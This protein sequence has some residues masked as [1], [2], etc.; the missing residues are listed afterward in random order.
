MSASPSREPRAANATHTSGGRRL[1]CA[2]AATPIEYALAFI[3]VDDDGRSR[4]VSPIGGRCSRAG[5][6]PR[7]TVGDAVAADARSEAPPPLRSARLATDSRRVSTQVTFLGD[8]AV[9]EHGMT[10][11]VAHDQSTH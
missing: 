1:L 2:I 4:A 10:R 6:S 8:I 11:V 7:R 5:G 3:R 9:R